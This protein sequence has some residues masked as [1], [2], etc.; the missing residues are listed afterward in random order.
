MTPLLVHGQSEPRPRPQLAGQGRE[1]GAQDSQGNAKTRD[2]KGKRARWTPSARPLPRQPPQPRQE[3]CRGSLP[4]A[5]RVHHPWAEGSNSINHIGTKARGAPPWWHADLCEDQKHTRSDEDQKT[6]S[7]GGI[8]AEETRE[9]PGKILAGDDRDAT[10]RPLPG[11]STSPFCV[12]L[13]SLCSGSPLP[14]CLVWPWARLRL[15]VHK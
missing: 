9:T 13:F 15:P 7:L 5:N 4:D 3:P 8:L 1:A 2:T 14:P 12:A 11:E 6:T 10:A